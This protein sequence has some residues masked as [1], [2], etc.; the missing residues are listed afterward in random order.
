MTITKKNVQ[1]KSSNATQIIATPFLDA[2]IA[3]KCIKNP[4]FHLL[5]KNVIFYL[6]VIVD[7]IPY[8]IYGYIIVSRK[9]SILG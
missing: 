7:D 5:G 3:S 9:F 6:S 4:I 8:V 2:I 1:Q